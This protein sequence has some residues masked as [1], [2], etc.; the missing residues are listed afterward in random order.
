[1]DFN[2]V[3]TWSKELYSIAGRHFKSLTLSIGLRKLVN[4]P[5]HLRSDGS[6]SST[7]ELLL[8]SEKNIVSSVRAPLPG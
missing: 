6:L 8:S 4:F 1:M 7:L 3:G 5:T 2:D